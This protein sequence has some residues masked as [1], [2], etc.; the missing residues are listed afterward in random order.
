MHLLQS[1]DLLL[2]SHLHLVVL[3]PLVDDHLG[4]KI[5]EGLAPQ[6]PQTKIPF[7]APNSF[8]GCNIK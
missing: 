5:R 7:S 8:L 3:L 2:V 6:L 4:L 1:G